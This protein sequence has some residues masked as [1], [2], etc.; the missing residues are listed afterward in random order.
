MS[1][2][3]KGERV[4][5]EGAVVYIHLVERSAGGESLIHIDVEHP[6]LNDIIVS[7]ESTYA[8]GKKGGIFI[9]L[10]LQ[11]AQRAQEYVQ[12]RL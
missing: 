11:Q 10:R 1:E 9:G 3:E 5:L 8:G 2:E 12:A 4:V 7:R 6:D